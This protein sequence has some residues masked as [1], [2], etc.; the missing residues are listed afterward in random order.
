MLAEEA[1]MDGWTLFGRYAA[2]PR[3]RINCCYTPMAHCDWSYIRLSARRSFRGA[4]STIPTNIAKT[5]DVRA[6]TGSASS[7]TLCLAGLSIP[8]KQLIC[9]IVRPWLQSLRTPYRA[10]QG[11]QAA[12]CL[13]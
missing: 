7:T 13:R 12:R 4:I 5:L 6:D 8:R 1:R 3:S 2:D 11:D 9:A 10:Q